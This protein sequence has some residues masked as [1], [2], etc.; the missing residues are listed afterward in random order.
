MPAG[1]HWSPKNCAGLLDAP[2]VMGRL[3]TESMGLLDVPLGTG[4]WG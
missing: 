3:G 1:G 2:R 4:T